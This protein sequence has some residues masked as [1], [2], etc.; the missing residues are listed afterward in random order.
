[1]LSELQRQS[2]LPP[3]CL[4][5]ESGRAWE[6]VAGGRDKGAGQ[7]LG[8]LGEQERAAGEKDKPLPEKGDQEK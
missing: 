8:Q 2:Q 7:G 6:V 3:D 4:W 5:R 1:M